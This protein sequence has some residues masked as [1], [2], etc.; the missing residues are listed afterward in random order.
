MKP[1]ESK[2]ALKQLEAIVLIPTYNNDKTLSK[3]IDEVLMYAQDVLVVNDGS[4]DETFTILSSRSDISVLHLPK[5]KGKGYA[6][7]TGIRASAKRGFKYAI[8]IDSDGQHYA[9]DLPVFIEAAQKSPDVLYVGGRNLQADNMPSKNT[10][11]NRFSNFWFW[12]ETGVELSDTQS[13]YRWYPLEKISKMKFVSGRYELELELMVRAAWKGIPVEN[14]PINVYYPPVEERV[15]HFH[16][17]IDFT[18]ISILNS[19]LI[20]LALVFYYP[21]RFLSLLSWT[22][23]KSFFNKNI[24]HSKDSNLRLCLSIFLG[25]TSSTLPIWGFQM[26]FCI[27]IAHIF[28]LNKVVAVAAANLSI[29]PVIPF[30][31]FGSY[32][33]GAKLL[34]NPLVLSFNKINKEDAMAN[35]VQYLAGSVVLALGLGLLAGLVS[36]LLLNVFRKNP[37]RQE[38]K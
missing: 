17:I 23:I 35:L 26:L 5:N 8:S 9:S 30:L 24:L 15:S 29:P 13:G 21:W 11:A 7:K 10:F 22:N 14:L 38:A 33:I 16:P 3:V 28:K 25:V 1:E 6:L 12:A 20:L 32:A 37:V 31:L 34:G 36:W 18:R 27:L 19:H 4:T 2:I